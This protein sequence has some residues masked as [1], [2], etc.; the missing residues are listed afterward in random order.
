MMQLRQYIHQLNNSE[1]GKTG[2]HETYV[3]V[4]RGMA[5]K[6]EFIP[7]GAFQVK[8][9]QNSCFYT[10][11]FKKC[12]NG[13][14]RLTGLGEIYRLSGANAGDLFLFNVTDNCFEVDF[15]HRTNLIVFGAQGD[16]FEC[17]NEDRISTILDR[18]LQCYFGGMKTSISIMFNKKMK[19]RSDSKREVNVYEIRVNGSRFSTS[20]NQSMNLYDFSGVYFFEPSPLDI[21]FS[22]D[23]SCH[24]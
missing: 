12:K 23:R 8:Y 20:R 22:L 17:R 24:A 11:S 5:G 18:E 3:S 6:L 13:E 9:K 2:T 15:V 21:V 7:G 10:L 14:L 1:L 16:M 4:P 19:P